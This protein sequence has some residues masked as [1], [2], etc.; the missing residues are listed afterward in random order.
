[1]QLMS[2]IKV[3]LLSPCRCQELTLRPAHSMSVDR[4]RK[5][6]IFAHSPSGAWLTMS[7]QCTCAS[8]WQCDCLLCGAPSTSRYWY[9]PAGSSTCSCTT[10]A[11]AVSC[12]RATAWELI[13]LMLP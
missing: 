11:R 1:M 5:G 2:M 3:L 12:G 13:L 9:F 6:A 7:A 10:H 8:I 4:M